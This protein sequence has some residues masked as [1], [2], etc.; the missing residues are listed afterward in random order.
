MASTYTA[1]NKIEKPASGDQNGSWDVTLRSNWD[2]QDEAISGYTTQAITTADV[3]L[4]MDVTSCVARH[5]VIELTGPSTASRNLIV[6]AIEKTWIIYN[7]TDNGYAHTVKVSGQ[8]GVSVPNGKKMLLYCDGTDVKEGQNYSSGAMPLTGGT[9]T[10]TAVFAA[11]TTTVAPYK[12]QAGSVLTTPVAHSVEWD[13]TYLYVTN[14]SASRKTVAYTDSSITGSAAT[15]TTTRSISMTGH[16]T[17]TV[18]FNGSANATA[19]MTLA[20]TGVTAGSYTNASITVDAYG[21]LTAASTGSGGGSTS[22]TYSLTMNSSGTGDASGATFNGSAAKTISYNTIGAAPLASP[23]FTGTITGAALTLSGTFTANGNSVIGSDSSD[24]LTVNAT[25]TFANTVSFNGP[26]NLGNASG[27]TI[28][29]VGHADFQNNVT[30]GSASG[31]TVTVNGTANFV[32]QPTGIS[33]LPV[34]VGVVTS[35]GS[36]NG[37][38]TGF[39]SSSRT[40]TG[41]F[42]VTLSSAPTNGFPLITPLG[43]TALAMNVTSAPGATTITVE[44]KNIAGS[45]TDPDYFSIVVY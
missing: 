43:S 8:T 3:T 26:V 23:A 13:G 37:N 41:R 2:L 5:A 25:S 31:D 10:G 15:L 39:A 36:L 32:T 38:S 1:S 12:F 29:A 34:G 4:T 7:H 28:T 33:G 11:G 18:N 21:R 20:T 17:W 14:S 24:T 45:Y 16:G 40:N 27:D 42:S 6:P 35:G 19:A 22:T 30:L 9:M 44:F